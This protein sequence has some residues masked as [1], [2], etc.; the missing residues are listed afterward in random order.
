M[1]QKEPIFNK[2]SSSAAV[3]V[4][5]DDA[6][7]AI[8]AEY[9]LK[10]DGFKVSLAAPPKDIRK[11]CDLGVQVE[12]SHQIEVMKCLDEKKIYYIDLIGFTGGAEHVELTTFKEL[13]GFIM[14]KSGNMKLTFKK[15]SGMIVNISGGGC[16]DIPYLAKQLVNTKLNSAPYPMDIGHSLCAY[17]LDRALRRAIMYMEGTEC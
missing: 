14:V 16:P 11:G 4:L 3:L 15:D 7:T 1:K 9:A 17:L 12:P 10:K 5:F 13:D 6:N 2:A 8:R